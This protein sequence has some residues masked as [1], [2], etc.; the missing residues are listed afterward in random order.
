MEIME[1]WRHLRDGREESST[2]S[3]TSESEENETRWSDE[4]QEKETRIRK[5][6]R[7]NEENKENSRL[8]EERWKGGAENREDVTN[9]P[10]EKAPS[11]EEDMQGMTLRRTE[12][13]YGADDSP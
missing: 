4:G 1:T 2:D 7:E 5:G 3:S 9:D 13:S 10:K 8:K 12:R 11:R 6:D